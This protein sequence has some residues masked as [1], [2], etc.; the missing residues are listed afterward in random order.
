MMDEEVEE[1]CA[2]EG[3]AATSSS[4]LDDTN[5]SGGVD[6]AGRVVRVLSPPPAPAAGISTRSSSPRGGYTTDTSS[7]SSV[8][9]HNNTTAAIVTTTSSGA[10]TSSGTTTTSSTATTG[11]TT[12]TT[13]EIRECSF[14]QCGDDFLSLHRRIEWFMHWFIESASAIDQDDRW[15]VVLPYIVS[16]RRRRHSGT[17]NNNNCC[18][19][20]EEED[21]HVEGHE[22]ATQRGGGHKV[23]GVGRGVVVT[24]TKKE[25]MSGG[26]GGEELCCT[27]AAGCELFDNYYSLVGIAT[28]YRFFTIHNDRK[29]I[30]Q[31]M[32]FPHV[33]NRG[34]GMHLLE[35]LSMQALQG[36]DICELTVEDPAPSFFQLRDVVSLRVCLLTHQIP[37]RALYPFSYVQKLQHAGS[38]GG[39]NTFMCKLQPFVISFTSQGNTKQITQCNAT[40]TTSTPTDNYRN[41]KSVIHK[42][43][44]ENISPHPGKLVTA[45]AAVAETS[46][47]KN[48]EEQ[49]QTTTTPSGIPTTKKSFTTTTGVEHLTRGNVCGWL[50]DTRAGELGVDERILTWEKKELKNATKETYRQTIRM[51]ETLHLAQ[52]IP[53]PLPPPPPALRALTS[54]SSSSS[55][56]SLPAVACGGNGSGSNQ[57]SSCAAS[58]VVSNNNSSSKVVVGE[59]GTSG[60]S[61]VV[62]MGG[63]GRRVGA[64]G[65]C[66]DDEFYSSENCLGVR[67]NIKKRLK[68]DNVEML[69]EY[70]CQQVRSE[71]EKEWRALYSIYYRTIRKLRGQFPL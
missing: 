8:Y 30:S 62:V 41:S 68:K 17:Y 60:S 46:T 57:T 14:S 44:S 69:S 11:G 15:R 38:S 28:T 34:L 4:T 42:K 6:T 53:H 13:L 39:G 51:L 1:C 24:K 33:Q 20:Q 48:E 58:D 54:T 2:A 65:G 66:C 31:F 55:F 27:G 26:K 59:D 45:A 70:T 35:Y 56:P 23:G 7:S 9:G 21:E 32:I 10:T 37:V 22:A 71:L 36:D 63:S 5:S 19:A 49:K 16:R 67:L 64:G 61:R 43:H 40:T 50:F 3:D 52:L 18:L 12:T 29:R 47:T 25:I